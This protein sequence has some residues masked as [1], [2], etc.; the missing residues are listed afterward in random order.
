MCTPMSSIPG[1][2]WIWQKRR[3]DDRDLG[4]F[5]IGRDLEIAFFIIIPHHAEAAQVWAL[6]TCPES[7]EACSAWLC[8]FLHV[9]FIFGFLLLGCFFCGAKF[10]L[11]LVRAVESI[12]IKVT[13]WDFFIRITKSRILVDLAWWCLFRIPAFEIQL[14]HGRQFPSDFHLSMVAVVSYVKKIYLVTNMCYISI[15]VP[16]CPIIKPCFV[17]PNHFILTCA[18]EKH[19]A[20]FQASTIAPPQTLLHSSTGSARAGDSSVVLSFAS[21]GATKP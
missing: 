7:V 2:S 12:Y 4:S 15:S 16:G 9:Y 17:V 14:H 3:W 10:R 18:S 11:I 13:A 20:P 8:E 5:R 21:N 19:H 1:R 6:F